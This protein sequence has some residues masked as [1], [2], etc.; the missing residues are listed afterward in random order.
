ME[1]LQLSREQARSAQRREMEKLE[2]EHRREMSR[3]ENNVKVELAK[4]MT[5]VR[6]EEKRLLGQLEQGRLV[7]NVV[8]GAWGNIVTHQDHHDPNYTSSYSHGHSN[9]TLSAE[10]SSAHIPNCCTVAI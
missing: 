3:Q 4:D 5:E 1:D 10:R 8:E 7:Y 2:G 9:F 6:V